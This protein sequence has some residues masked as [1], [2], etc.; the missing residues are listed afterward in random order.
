MTETQLKATILQVLGHIAPEA[1][2]AALAPD[3]N[4]REALD[5]DSFDHLNFLV[6]LN[7]ALGV[8]IPEADYG[9]LTTLAD[10]LTYLA[11]RLQ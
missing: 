5:I 3:A 1:D 2:L 4:V 11:S 10:I 9:Q 6:G 8:E 7:D